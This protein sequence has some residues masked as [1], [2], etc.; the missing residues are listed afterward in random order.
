MFLRVD[1]YRPVYASQAVLFTV[2]SLDEVEAAVAILKSHTHKFRGVQLKSSLFSTISVVQLESVR[3]VSVILEDVLCLDDVFLKCKDKYFELIVPYSLF[4]ADLLKRCERVDRV[5]VSFSCEGELV[6]LNDL[7]KAFVTFRR[8][9]LLLNVPLC[10]LDV[11]DVK[12]AAEIYMRKGIQMVDS[13]IGIGSDVV[14]PM[15]CGGCVLPQYCSFKG[16]GFIPVP[17]LNSPLNCQKYEGVFSFL[18][19]EDSTARF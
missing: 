1:E 18:A 15:A 17:I 8:F 19:N 3:A 4:S 9:P 16:N 5:I 11:R 12:H 2:D 7:F 6:G 10:K 14:K 13:G